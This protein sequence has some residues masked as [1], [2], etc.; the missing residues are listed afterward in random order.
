M[1]KQLEGRKTTL[2]V[3]EENLDVANSRLKRKQWLNH[4]T[5]K[6]GFFQL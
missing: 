4:I 6:A 1:G 5:N 2:A 3:H